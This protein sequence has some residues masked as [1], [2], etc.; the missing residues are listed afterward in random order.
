V[1]KASKPINKCFAKGE[2]H[3]TK[4]VALDVTL[5]CKMLES[6]ESYTFCEM[7]EVDL[8]LDDI[9]F[10]VHSVDVR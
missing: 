1:Q 9:L 6:R 8:I 5:K 4:E 2:P 3:K 7:D 10:V